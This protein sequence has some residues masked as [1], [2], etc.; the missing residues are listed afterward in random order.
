[1]QLLNGSSRHGS[2]VIELAISLALI[3]GV[4]V[5]VHSFQHSPDKTQAALQA[6]ISG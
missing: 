3:V 5:S 2:L 6:A 4:G 1:M